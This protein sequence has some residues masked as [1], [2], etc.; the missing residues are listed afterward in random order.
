MEILMRKILLATAAFV[1][2]AAAAPSEAA[3]MQCAPNQVYVG[4]GQFP[5]SGPY[6]A[7]TAGIVTGVAANDITALHQSGCVQVGIAGNTLVGR[8]LKAN[9]NLAGAGTPT[10]DQTIPL[11][12]STG[13]YVRYTKISVKNCTTSMTT[14]VGGIYTATSQGGT[15]IVAAGQA[16][17]NST[18]ATIVTDLTIA[19]TPAKTT[20]GGLTA[21]AL[22]INLSTAQG[23]ASTCDFF[24]YGDVG[25]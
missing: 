24:V 7:D 21:P 14:A 4:S 12:L 15:A 20:Y 18:G 8:L 2:L 10:E 16:Y 22:I 9:M 19:S 3:T 23:A 11:F 5:T 25:Q 13:Q 6:T 1:A 17:S